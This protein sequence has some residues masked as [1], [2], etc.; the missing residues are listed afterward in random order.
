MTVVI[1]ISTTAGS[2]NDRP[3]SLR[4]IEWRQA[5]QWHSAEL[6]RTLHSLGVS[7]RMPDRFAIACCHVSFTYAGLPRH[8]SSSASLFAMTSLTVFAEQQLLQR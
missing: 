6:H 1:F 8:R 4:P 5:R 2:I 7:N 3:Q